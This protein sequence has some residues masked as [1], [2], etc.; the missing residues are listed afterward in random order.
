[1]SG[2]DRVAVNLWERNEPLRAAGLRL[3]HRMMVMKLRSGELVVHSPV[4]FSDG[5]RDA[6]LELGAPGWF[7]APSRFHDL[8]W[9]DWF[10][11]FPKARFAAV[12]G[13]TKE[14][15]DLPFTDV[16]SG[17]SDFWGDELVV[18][19]VGGM[20]RLNEHVFLHSPSRSLI[21]ADLVFNVDADAQ[22][23][24]GKLI[25]RLNAIYRKPGTSRIFRALIKDKTAL[26][27]SLQ[28]VLSYDF[29]RTILGHG[30]SICGRSELETILRQAGLL[31][32]V[33]AGVSASW[34]ASHSRTHAIFS[35]R[36]V[37]TSRRN[38]AAQ[39]PRHRP[40]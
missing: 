34:A 32:K 39:I 38:L 14:H 4:R 7:I 28:R 40:R 26:R 15:P 29:D 24:V 3:G 9:A 35:D 21:V 23:S 18:L 16:V 1:M 12:P 17:E 33:K 5:L 8:Y 30:K 19:P 25:L 13:M 6:L 22:N 11:A 20:P 2:L 27:E 31:S 10:Q 36:T 37:K